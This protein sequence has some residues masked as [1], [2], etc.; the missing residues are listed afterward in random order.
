MVSSAANQGRGTVR[1]ACWIVLRRGHP[2]VT[3]QKEFWVRSGGRRLTG[4]RNGKQRTRK[5]RHTQCF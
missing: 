5:S 1:F 3:G 2:S 4:T